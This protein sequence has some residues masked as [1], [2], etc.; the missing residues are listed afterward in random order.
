VGAPQ[1]SA[2]IV[3]VTRELTPEEYAVLDYLYDLLNAGH[4]IHPWDDTPPGKEGGATERRVYS[5]L[6]DAGLLEPYGGRERANGFAMLVRL[7]PDGR[8]LMT[9]TR[10][11]RENRRARAQACRN[12]L[13]RWYDEQPRS[14]TKDPTEFVGSDRSTFY[15]RQF[16]VDEAR[17]AAERLAEGGYLYTQRSLAGAVHWITGRGEQVM[18]EG[19]D[20]QAW[21]AS[22]R[23]ITPSTTIYNG[24]AVTI[25]GDQAQVAWGKTVHQTQNAVDA[26]APGFEAIAAAMAD[27]LRQLP[28]VGLP[29][30]DQQ[31]AEEAARE[32]L[33]EVTQASP[34]QGKVRRSIKVVKGALASVAAG[35]VTGGIEGTGQDIAQSLLE[36]LSNLPL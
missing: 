13:L 11:L 10:E 9:A 18:E 12:R 31:D 34:D 8:K 7:T 6:V 33:A 19:G 22:Q 28:N 16:S 36:Q 14:E 30:A 21:E 17:R 25:H 15:G 35:L 24:P 3:A 32:V 20:V 2:R 5:S 29:A 26:V 1:L 4:D 27:I 23:V